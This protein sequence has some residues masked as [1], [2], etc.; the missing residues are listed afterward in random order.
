MRLTGPGVIGPPSDLHE[1]RRVLTRAVEL[2]VNFI[3]T[4]D[5][6]GPHV[7]EEIIADALHPYPAGLVIATK[8]GYERP[9]PRQWKINGRPERLRAGCEGSLKRL[10]VDRIDLFQLHRIDPA[11]PEADQFLGDVRAV[12]VGGV[13][14]VDTEF[15]GAAQHANAFVAVLGRTPDPFTGQAHRAESQAVDRE[16]AADGERS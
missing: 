7:S 13:D 16:V 6:Y 12:R 9:G 4:A 5:S 11:V 8:A 1:A 15:D 3:D 2:G 10:R 14:E